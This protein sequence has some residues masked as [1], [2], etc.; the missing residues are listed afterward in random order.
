MGKR[1]DQGQM[2]GNGAKTASILTTPEAGPVNKSRSSGATKLSD[3][4]DD[5]YH[6]AR[7]QKAQEEARALRRRNAMD[8]GTFVLAS[9]TNLVT[10]QLLAKEIAQFENVLRQAAR[11]VADDLGVDFKEV[12]AL[13]I[14]TWR[15]HRGK[16]AQLLT[17]QGEV[18]EMSD[19]EKEADI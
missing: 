8:E 15:E 12:R 17:E 9:E 2:M 10:Q 4:D 11:K 7:T 18:I 13:L 5:A 16:R 1:L 6:M 14:A 19:A 3:G